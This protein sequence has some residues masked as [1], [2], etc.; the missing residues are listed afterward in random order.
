MC[1]L[2]AMVSTELHE[3]LKIPVLIEHFKKHKAEDDKMSL[4]TFLKLHYAEVVYDDDAAEDEQLPF[5]SFNEY[6]FSHV[7]CEKPNLLSVQHHVECTPEEDVRL[8]YLSSHIPV[9]YLSDIWQPPK[10]S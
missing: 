8:G 1:V 10:H 7:L 3:I 4:L 9:I 2:L 6:N 5:M